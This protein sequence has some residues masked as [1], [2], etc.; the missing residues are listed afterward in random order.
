MANTDRLTWVD[1]LRLT[2]G[3]SMVALHAT[4]DPSGQPWSDYEM[5]QRVAPIL[6]RAV[7]Y[8]ARTEL[9]II[10]SVF[11]LMLALDKRP[12]SYRSCISEQVQRLLVPF[13]FWTGFYALYGLIKAQSFGYFDAAL[14]TV[15]N[16]VEWIGFLLLGD[17]K[18]HMH[19]IPTLFAILL[20]FPLYQI[21][22]RFPV[23]GVW[24]VFALLVKAELDSFIYSHF[25]GNDALPFLVRLAKILTYV[26]YGMIAAA[27][28]GLIK[29]YCGKD[30]VPWIWPCA[31]GGMLLFMIKLV[32]SYKTIV[33]GEY[34]FDYRAG[35]WADFLMPVALFICAMCLGAKKWPAILSRLA[36]YSFGIY[37]THPIF[38]DLA[39]IY[40]RDTQLS[41]IEQVTY[42]I[43]FIIPTTFLLVMAM[44][45][46][47]PLSWT[48]GLG[49]FPSVSRFSLQK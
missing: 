27:C 46:C 39:E 47:R 5:S 16:P 45:R 7:F 2:A 34:P 32:G 33:T 22:V 15:S 37:L 12:R 26:G 6:L 36:P 1:A 28:Y 35:Y 13:A 18:Y 8:V 38:L 9:F 49:P 19:F 17:V 23:L 43:G 29:K 44:K 40:L 24:I 42:K 10:I 11:L 25:W 21:A 48:I 31:Y 41:P 14:A 30:F 4:A 20:F 3:L